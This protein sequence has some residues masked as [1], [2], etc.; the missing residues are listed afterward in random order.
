VNVQYL[1]PLVNKKCFVYLPGGGV[2]RGTLLSIADD[3]L[4]IRCKEEKRGGDKLDVD[5][6][7]SRHAVQ[8]V[9]ENV[10]QRVD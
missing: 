2:L 3:H 10:D 6:F 4:V 7:V 5:K 1:K 8:W 9:E